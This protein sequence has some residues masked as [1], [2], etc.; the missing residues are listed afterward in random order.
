MTVKTLMLE[1][2]EGEWESPPSCRDLPSQI[3]SERVR[4]DPCSCRKANVRLVP[5][6]HV[7]SVYYHRKFKHTTEDI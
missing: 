6:T 1:N 5:C 7:L 3:D 4:S 2:L